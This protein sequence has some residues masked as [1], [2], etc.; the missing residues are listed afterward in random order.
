MFIK[1]SFTADTRF[2]IPLRIIADI[3]NTSSI[4]SVSALQSRFTSA[5]YS[6]TLT[7]NFDANNSTIIRTVNPANTKAH[8]FTNDLQNAML[9]FTLEQPVYD[10]PSSNVYTRIVGPAG[11]GYAYF[12]VGTAIT[13]GTMSS[14]SM[15]VTFSEITAGTSG[16][17]LTLGGN[18]YGN[19]SPQLASGSGHANIRTFWAY[20][21]DK[22][23]FWAVTNATSYNV[24]WGTSY[25]NSS[26]Q[27][28]PFFQTQYTRFDY[29]NLDSNGIYPVLYTSQRGAGIG[30]GTNND[31]TTV[32]NLYFTTNTTT[33]PLRVHSIVSALPQVATAWPR[34]YNQGVHMT[35]NGRTSGNYGL[36]TVQTAGTLAS[37]VLPSYSGSYSNVTS[38]RYPSADLAST[39]FGLMPFGWEATPYGNYGG[40]ASD[41]CGVYI[42][43]GEY[44][45]GDTFVYNTKTYM[46]WPMYQGNGQ[47]V[48]FAVPME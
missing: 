34:I 15:P 18:N 24:G 4:T 14:T 6:A 1:L 10:A 16:T 23:F 29:H 36:Q 20:I 2:T 28:G 19:I 27:G 43:N 30:Y 41:Q 48:G 3:V 31:L 12:E 7:A 8:V 39:G 33:L 40:N 5:S 32:Q 44:T 46:I 37:A 38:N 45:P 35:M 9:N 26:I 25:S 13:G 11:T 17:N 47:R 42:F 21:T 22:C